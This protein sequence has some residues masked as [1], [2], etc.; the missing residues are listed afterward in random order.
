VTPIAWLLAPTWGMRAI[1]HAALGGA[2][3]PDIGVCV[4]LS[5]AY[6]GIAAVCLRGLE[7]LARGRA[8]LALS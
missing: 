6:L 5:I 3:L 4:G 1:R 2:A 7:Q 8:T